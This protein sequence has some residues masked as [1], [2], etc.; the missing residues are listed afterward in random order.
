M[1]NY[2]HNSTTTTAINIRRMHWVL[3][4]EIKQALS[5]THVQL[6]SDSL[7]RSTIRDVRYAET[8]ANR[9]GNRL[10]LTSARAHS[11]FHLPILYM[12]MGASSSIKTKQS[13]HVDGNHARL[14]HLIITANHSWLTLWHFS[15]IVASGF[16]H[17]DKR[18]PQQ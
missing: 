6:N 4:I 16:G 1:H 7:I 15:L 18:N 5:K 9:M 3:Q 17:S 10:M 11:M 8:L 13:M 2:I 14:E 12:Y